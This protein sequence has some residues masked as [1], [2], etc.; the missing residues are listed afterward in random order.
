ME[1]AGQKSTSRTARHG[2]VLP[3]G[4]LLPRTAQQGLTLWASETWKGNPLPEPS[5][6]RR[7]GSERSQVRAK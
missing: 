2:Q 6:H 5:E 3:L 4:C 1:G 7:G